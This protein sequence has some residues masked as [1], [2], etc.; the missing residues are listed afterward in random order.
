MIKSFLKIKGH[1]NMKLRIDITFGIELAV[2]RGRGQWEE[3]YP[4]QYKLLVAL[5][6][7]NDSFVDYNHK[8]LN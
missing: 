8:I 1:M 7:L 5:Q 4:G 2:G 3:A 6:F